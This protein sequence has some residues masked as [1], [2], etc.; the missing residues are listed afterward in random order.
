MNRLLKLVIILFFS[1]TIS[2]IAQNVITEGKIVYNISY[3]G[4]E[5][6]SN[7]KAMM[8][9]QSIVYFKDQK[10]RT[11]MSFSTGIFTASLLDSKSGEI[12]TL[13]DMMGTKTA[14]VLTEKD[15]QNAKKE[16]EKS[17]TKY[18]PIKITYEAETKKVA[19]YSCKK[20][21]I[22]TGSE[23]YPIEIFYT[24]QIKSITQLNSS[25]ENFDGFPLEYT[26]NMEGVM[27]KLSASEV[28]V[29]NVDD[30][31]FS[32]PSDYKVMTTMEMEKMMNLYD[33]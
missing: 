31:L 30:S 10:S 13:T 12:I 11:E 16:K 20:A 24:D 17:G 4:M 2:T 28:A 21:L 3:P 9:S 25:W 7:Y 19:G 15:Q 8:P 26:L 6:D 27:M 14:I 5:M 33:K 29:G 23:S 18:P 32:I 1:A 22:T